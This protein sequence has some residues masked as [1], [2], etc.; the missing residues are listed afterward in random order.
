MLALRS[1]LVMTF[2]VSC[3]I[4]SATPALAASILFESRSSFELAAQR[5]AMQVS[6]P[7]L[8]T[9]TF[10]EF[11]TGHVCAEMQLSCSFGTRGITFATPVGGNFFIGRDSFQTN[12][13]ATLGAL[14]IPAAPDEFTVTFSSRFIGLDVAV[15]GP[16]TAVTFVLSESDGT[17]TS[18][19]ISAF[20]EFG[21]GITFF[22]AISDIS[23]EK[24]S[25]FKPTS[26]SGSNSNFEIDNVSTTIIPEPDT[27]L[28]LT[29]GLTA[30]A[31][32]SRK[33]LALR[34]RSPLH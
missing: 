4:L 30:M 26:P 5:I 17:R 2:A 25:I 11:P 32:F 29:F 7:P 13:T 28:L 1:T 19:T 34:E 18:S 33:G 9:I 10:E 8:E 20:T 31:L 14:G 22:G 3:A 24:I 6:T 16:P 21:G 23:F 15:A 27:L 12:P